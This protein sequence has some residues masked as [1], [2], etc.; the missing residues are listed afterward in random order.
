MAAGVPEGL[1]PELLMVGRAN[2]QLLRLYVALFGSHLACA[3]TCPRCGE[4]LELEIDAR[5]LL[6]R[7]P[8]PPALPV[9]FEVEGWDISFRPPTEGDVDAVMG[10]RN[11]AVAR[12][13]LLQRC[14][15]ECRRGAE[16]M[17]SSMVP[18]EVMA[19]VSARM[20]ELDPLATLDFDLGCGRCAHGWVSAL[21]VDSLLWVQLDAWARRLLREV[22]TLAKAYSWSERDILTM[23]PW[24][25]QLY[26]DLVD[27]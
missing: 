4:A 8:A 1:S 16:R 25:R 10:E 13:M 18:A 12:D 7:E 20:G 14:V 9:R 19:S 26:L 27:E 11:A 23:S 15:N 6:A 17:T 22:H 21:E 3:T 24:K 2:A 5:E